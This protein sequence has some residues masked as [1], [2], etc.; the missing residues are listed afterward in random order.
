MRFTRGWIAWCFYGFHRNCCPLDEWICHA[1]Q[2]PDQKITN[3]WRKID[4]HDV[5]IDFSSFSLKRCLA[6]ITSMTG[7]FQKFNWQVFR[8]S[9]SAVKQAVLSSR[10][11]IPVIVNGSNKCGRKAKMLLLLLFDDAPPPPKIRIITSHILTYRY[12]IIS[13]KL[14]TIDWIGIVQLIW[15][16]YAGSHDDCLLKAD[17]GCISGSSHSLTVYGNKY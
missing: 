7:W 6:Q 15:H 9:L 3:E 5:L 16:I 17:R 12:C 10:N 8:W 11:I 1:P 14:F 2:E 13:F 4:G